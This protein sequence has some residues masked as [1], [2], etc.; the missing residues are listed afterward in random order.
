MDVSLE[1]LEGS[2]LAGGSYEDTM[3]A[4]FKASNGLTM[5]EVAKQT[6][7]GDVWDPGGEVAMLISAGKEGR[8]GRV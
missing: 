7:K 6:K 1:I 4:S 2:K 5:D 3:H 8:H